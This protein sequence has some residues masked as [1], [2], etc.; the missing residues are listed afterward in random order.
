MDTRAKTENWV[1][2]CAENEIEPGDAMKLDVTPPVAVFNVD[3]EFFAT[4]DTCTHAVSSLSD[5]YITK[6]VVEC[7]FHFAKFDV[8]TGRALCLPAT[9]PLRTFGVR[10]E[11]GYVYVDVGDR[12]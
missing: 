5:G 1:R 2:A 3:G 4:D 10:L 7:A 6:D 8:R 9:Q 11:G 12:E